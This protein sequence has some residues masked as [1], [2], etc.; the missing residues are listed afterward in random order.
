MKNVKIVM[1]VIA[2]LAPAVIYLL[3][4]VLQ[5]KLEREASELYLKE[6]HLKLDNDDLEVKAKLRAK[7]ILLER[8][9]RGVYRTDE[10]LRSANDVL[11]ESEKIAL[12]F[13]K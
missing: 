4:V 5:R 13:D 11:Y 10:E 3:E 9:N 2:V 12:R 6:R 8:W 7:E 1:F